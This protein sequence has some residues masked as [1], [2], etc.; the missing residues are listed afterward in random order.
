MSGSYTK[1]SRT[2]SITALNAT[3]KTE[4]RTYRFLC[5]D[6]VLFRTVHID[7]SATSVEDA[8]DKL[9]KDHWSLFIVSH[10]EL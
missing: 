9:M 7:V 2:G 5:K 8:K 1:A 4:E 10:E 3:K 6:T